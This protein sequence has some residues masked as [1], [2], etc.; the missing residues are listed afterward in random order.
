MRSWRIQMIEKY[1]LALECG[2]LFAEVLGLL[3]GYWNWGMCLVVII[4]A[5]LLRVLDDCFD[6]DIDRRNEVHHLPREFFQIL[7]ALLIAG[8][9]G[10][11]LASM[12]WRGLLAIPLV[13][14][15]MI[16]NRHEFL[17]IFLVALTSLYYLWAYGGR[18]DLQSVIFIVLL[19]MI[20]A[21]YWAY[22]QQQNGYWETN[23]EGKM[24]RRSAIYKKRQARKKKLASKKSIA[25]TTNSTTKNTKT[26]AVSAASTKTIKTAS[27][28]TGVKKP[29][30]ATMHKST[31]K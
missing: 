7:A 25:K 23:G 10:L 20:A 12:D 5:M 26:P 9:I 19:V 31:R 3:I 8:Y 16:A 14:Y 24:I 22:Q 17:K 21:T 18:L 15:M 6:Y 2:V 27:K 30:T 28:S 1:L 13:L 29:Q 4:N 11:S